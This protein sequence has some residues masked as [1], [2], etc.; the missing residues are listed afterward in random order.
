MGNEKSH[1][2]AMMEEIWEIFTTRTSLN[3][4][5]SHCPCLEGLAWIHPAKGAMTNQI[6][7]LAVRNWDGVQDEQVWPF[8][9]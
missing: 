5:L 9:V 3:P 8:G 7:S 2:V 6:F 4:A 1:D